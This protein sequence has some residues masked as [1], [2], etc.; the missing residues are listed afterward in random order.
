MAA[1]CEG[2][3]TWITTMFPTAA[4][5]CAA[6]GLGGSPCGTTFSHVPDRTWKTCTSWVA[7][8]SLMPAAAALAVRI[9]PASRCAGERRWETAVQRG[10]QLQ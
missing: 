9:G 6:R 4:A 7:P 5:A 2:G 8:A 10:S 3:R 1:Q